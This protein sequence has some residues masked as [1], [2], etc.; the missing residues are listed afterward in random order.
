MSFF[1]KIF[2]SN[3]KKTK[4]EE[5]T[6]AERNFQLLKDNK[7]DLD[8]V[9]GDFNSKINFLYKQVSELEKDNEA[10]S[11]RIKDLE[12]ALYSLKNNGD[13]MDSGIKSECQQQLKTE[14]AKTNTKESCSPNDQPKQNQNNGQVNPNCF[15]LI[16]LQNNE[17][18]ILPINNDSTPEAY[19]QESENNLTMDF[20]Q[21]N[22]RSTGNKSKRIKKKNI[23]SWGKEKSSI[24][25]LKKNKR[26]EISKPAWK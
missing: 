25:T 21:K 23:N 14:E 26:K 5:V 22:Y 17:E 2:G 11:N 7:F 24:K 15:E 1:K 13:Y 9:L 18:I 4:E 8:S 12:T 3:E 20:F 6:N 19:M 16:H 10:K